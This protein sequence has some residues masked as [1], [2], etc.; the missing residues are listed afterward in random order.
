[1]IRD[2]QCWDRRTLKRSALHRK[3]LGPNDRNFN[4]HSRNRRNICKNSTPK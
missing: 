4:G 1:M 2:S 3:K